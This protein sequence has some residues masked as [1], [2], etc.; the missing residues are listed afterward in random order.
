MT[1]V[2]AAGIGRVTFDYHRHHDEIDLIDNRKS[3]IMAGAGYGDGDF[4]KQ[5]V[6][7]VFRSMRRHLLVSDLVQTKRKE[8]LLDWRGG[9][10]GSDLAGK[11]QRD[12][13]AITRLPIIGFKVK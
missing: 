13:A 4:K 9:R 3:M 5:S 2:A 8:R 12:C 6:R 10:G 11:L 7:S 1:D